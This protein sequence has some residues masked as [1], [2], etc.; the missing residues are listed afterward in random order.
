MQSTL[1]SRS[2]IWAPR[3]V[4]LYKESKDLVWQTVCLKKTYALFDVFGIA[5]QARPAQKKVFRLDFDEN[6]ATRGRLLKKISEFHEIAAKYCT[7]LIFQKK[8]F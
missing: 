6:G 3:K 2:N 5:L 7:I 8:T 1:Q 4:D